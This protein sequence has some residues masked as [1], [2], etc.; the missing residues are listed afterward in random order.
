MKKLMNI[1]ILFLT[2]ILGLGQVR[3]TINSGYIVM[4]NGTSTTPT[5]IVVHN[6]AANAITRVGGG[7]I[8]ESEYNMVQWDIGNT[9]TTYIVPFQRS[10]TDYLPLTLQLTGAPAGAGSI[11]F[12]TWETNNDNVPRPSDVTNM[13]PY[14]LPGSPSN[15]DNS[16]NAADRFWVIDAHVAGFSY[17]TYPDPHITFT[18]QNSTNGTSEVGG[19]NNAIDNTLIAQRFNSTLGEW[20]DYMGANGTTVVTG[21]H[22]TVATGAND[23]KN[24][25]FFRSW[26][27][28]SHNSPL[29]I[30]L[31]TFTAEC[32]NYY[33]ELYWTTATESNNDYFTIDRTSDG[34]NFETIAVVKGS[35]TSGTPH[36][37]S[38]IDY[39]PLSSVSYYR[40]SQTDFDGVTTHFNTIVYVPCENSESEDAY[41]DNSNTV[42]VQI[43]SVAGDNYTISLLSILGQPVITENHSLPAGNSNIKLHPYVSPGVYILNLKSDKVN[44]NKKLYIG[45]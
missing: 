45:K 1:C 8:S 42:N 22:S 31:E 28:S 6:S 16:Y 35:G 44:Y 9:T 23:V 15:T 38:A 19:S 36:N 30:Q 26:V 5:L 17:T 33:A 11:R 13:F 39:S 12:S 14:A 21:T 41:V 43:N 20:G 34:I 7:M 18:Y 29:P 2:P 4:A 27:L 10:T 40:I 3:T 37:Y 25:G 32:S 24:T